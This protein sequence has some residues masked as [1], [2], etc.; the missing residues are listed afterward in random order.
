[1]S[2]PLYI[3]FFVPPILPHY[4]IKILTGN[5]ET[6]KADKIDIARV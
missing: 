1:L 3:S 5:E 6:A 4:F 2:L